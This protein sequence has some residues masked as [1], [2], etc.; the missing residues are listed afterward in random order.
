[1][2]LRRMEAELGS[3]LPQGVGCEAGEK[4]VVIIGRGLLRRYVADPVLRSML[5]KVR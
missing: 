5:G 2:K 3:V 4:S 1:M